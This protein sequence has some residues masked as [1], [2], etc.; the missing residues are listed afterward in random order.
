MKTFSLRTLGAVLCVVALSA[1]P[2]AGFAVAAQNPVSSA[3][4]V[5][6][7]TE[8]RPATILTTSDEIA[9]HTLP[10]D[11]KAV[12]YNISFTKGSLTNA[13][14]TPVGTDA[15]GW[16]PAGSITSAEYYKVKSLAQTLTAD[17][18]IVIRVDR[19]L[20]GAYA[21]AGLCVVGTG[22]ATSSSATTEYRFEY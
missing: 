17:D 1:L 10:L 18:K 11:V 8:L 22:T 15:P 20:F 5:T 2:T 19:E 7:A 21:Y 4:L 3:C 14:F 12:I 13:T 6:T 9:T 16:R